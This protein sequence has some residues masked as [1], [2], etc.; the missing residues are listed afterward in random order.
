[1]KTTIHSCV[2]QHWQLI[3]DKY[4]RDSDGRISLAE[5]RQMILSESFTKDIPQ[6]TVRQIQKRADE[7]AN[8]Y[9]EYPEFL[10]MV[11]TDLVEQFHKTWSC[12]WHFSKHP[13]YII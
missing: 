5:L 3:F 8:G 12:I 7:D 10:K 13:Y 1:V 2:L 4:D 6:H 9:I 11:C